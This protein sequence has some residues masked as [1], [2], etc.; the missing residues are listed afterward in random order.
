[1]NSH[2]YWE[3]IYTALMQPA[4]GQPALARD[5]QHHFQLADS[6]VNNA[7]AQGPP[8]TSY[9]DLSYIRELHKMTITV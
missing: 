3:Q 5:I 7:R 4:V 1:M 6:I 8:P 2:C 9:R